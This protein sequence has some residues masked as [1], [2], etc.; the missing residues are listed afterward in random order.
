MTVNEMVKVAV[1]VDDGV[2]GTVPDNGNSDGQLVVV[3]D[4]GGR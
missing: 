3:V 2:A 4:N 1:V